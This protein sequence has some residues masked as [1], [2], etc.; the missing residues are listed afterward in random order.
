MAAYASCGLHAMCPHRSYPVC[1]AR[2][3]TQW[4][5]RVG[6]NSTAVIPPTR[7]GEDGLLKTTFAMFFDTHLSV[8]TVAMHFDDS[9]YGQKILKCQLYFSV[10][11]NMAQ[12]QT[13]FVYGWSAIF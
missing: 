1:H 12:K 4:G 8:A 7:P 10:Q 6:N 13:S 2:G 9:L 5:N 3:L 11:T